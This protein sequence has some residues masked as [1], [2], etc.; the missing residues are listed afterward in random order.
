MAIS[1]FRTNPIVRVNPPRPGFRGIATIAESSLAIAGE[2]LGITQLKAQTA[3]SIVALQNPQAFIQKR[4]DFSS[5]ILNISN[6]ASLA[7]LNSQNLQFL[8]GLIGE[9]DVSL[10][11]SDDDVFNAVDIPEVLKSLYVNSN[12][13]IAVGLAQTFDPSFKQIERRVQDK[14]SGI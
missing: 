12:S 2:K 13:S 1:L 11:L 6:F 5:D 9:N 7:I 8:L 14:L 10:D 4:A 3:M